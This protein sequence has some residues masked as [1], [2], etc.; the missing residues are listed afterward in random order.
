MTSPAAASPFTVSRPREG[1]QSIKH[2]VVV[3]EHRLERPA[4][5]QLSTERG[6]ELDLGPGQV[7]TCRRDEQVAHRRRLDALVDGQVLHDDLVHGGLELAGVHPQPGRGI[8][9][10]IEVDDQRA[11]AERREAGTKVDGGGRLSHAALLI[12]DG[13]DAGQRAG[14]TRTGIKRLRRIV[15]RRNRRLVTHRCCILSII[16]GSV[17]HRFT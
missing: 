15:F 17:K 11:V 13:Q 12:G 2:E 16:A 8:A 10:G 3:G 5:L 7:E 4:E 9:L 1:G 14:R 6:D